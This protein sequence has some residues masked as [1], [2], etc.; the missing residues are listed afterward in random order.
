MIKSIF[1]FAILFFLIPQCKVIEGKSLTSIEHQ[2]F[3]IQLPEFKTDSCLNDLLYAIAIEDSITQLYTSS[4]YF[5]LLH[6]EKTS[7]YN[8][9]V[10]YPMR[11]TSYL[12]K[13]CK[14]ILIIYGRSFVLCGS[15][16]YNNSL[17]KK[18][19]IEILK[20]ISYK[21]IRKKEEDQLTKL[22]MWESS[23]TALIGSYILCEGNP[24][25]IYVN[26][27]KR[28]EGLYINE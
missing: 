26:I 22:R 2:K 20:V 9:I 12:P 5:Y 19:G 27:G 13:D 8:R 25:E 15:N 23:P 4:D 6:F 7:S 14:G 16:V 21:R 1:I 11:W 10:I 24:I 3:K 18:S 28:I 17:F